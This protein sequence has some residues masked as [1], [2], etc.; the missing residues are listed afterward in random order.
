MNE[1]NRDLDTHLADHR[2]KLKQLAMTDMGF[3]LDA[4]LDDYGIQRDIARA[5]RRERALVMRRI[6]EVS[7]RALFGRRDRKPEPRLE[8]CAEPCS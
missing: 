5:A 6:L 3:D 4:F 1:T 2:T 7:T 8:P